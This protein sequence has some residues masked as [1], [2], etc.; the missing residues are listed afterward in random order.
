M[1]LYD[2]DLT[3]KANIEF[4]QWMYAKV[5]SPEFHH[6]FEIYCN[7][8]NPTKL[9]AIKLV[10]ATAHVMVG[11]LWVFASVDDRTKFLNIYSQYKNCTYEN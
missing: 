8:V 6:L 2:S 9:P 10:E 7:I 1:K 3:K 4:K 5:T 11:R